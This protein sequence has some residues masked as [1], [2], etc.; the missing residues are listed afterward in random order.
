M[1]IGLVPQHVEKIRPPRALLVP[2]ELGRPLGEPGNPEAQA[3]V[4]KAALRLLDEPGPPP[5]VNSL[6]VTNA[7]TAASSEAREDWSCPVSFPEAAD[8]GLAAR[9]SQE[10]D[11]LM[12]WFEKARAERKH[13]VTGVSGLSPTEAATWLGSL[14]AAESVEA[15]VD[16]E[17]AAMTFK[18]AVE[19]IKAFYLEA[20]TAQPGGSSAALAQWLWQQTALGELLF[21]LRE[22][23]KDYEADP[24]LRIY[25]LATT[26]PGA[27][28]QR[29][30][31][32]NA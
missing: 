29:R 7:G 10:V 13:T 23:F 12:P 14:L 16:A 22:K 18:L 19:D 28:V 30:E 15:P 26:V 2:Y 11:L 5:R 17:S 32:K 3:E 21:D 9:V 8:S 6:P 4:L 25:A 31:R 24:Q 27:E 1:L 20:A